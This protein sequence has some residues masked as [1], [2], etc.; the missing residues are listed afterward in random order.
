MKKTFQIVFTDL[1]AAEMATLPTLLQLDILG[2]FEAG[3][4]PEEAEAA[5]A[6][7]FGRVEGQGRSLNRFRA[8]DYRIYYEVAPRE[9]SLLIRRVLHKN[10]L[11]DFLFRSN[12]PGA[13]EDEALQDNPDFWKMMDERK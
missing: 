5:D 1:S 13:G 10:T 11:K 9:R 6:E 4:L 7:K 8:G 2:Q 3:A 12:L